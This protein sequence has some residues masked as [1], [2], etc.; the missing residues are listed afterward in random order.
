MFVYVSGSVSVCI[1]AYVHVCT[2]V[3]CRLMEGLV[4]MSM[5]LVLVGSVIIH[6][7]MIDFIYG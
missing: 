5:V 6:A 4:N 2:R 7:Y 3:L 1:R